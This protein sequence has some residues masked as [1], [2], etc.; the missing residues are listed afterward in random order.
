MAESDSEMEPSTYDRQKHAPLPDWYLFPP[1]QTSGTTFRLGQIVLLRSSDHWYKP[2]HIIRVD[3]KC[4]EVCLSETSHKTRL[5]R[6]DQRRLL[7]PY[8]G[9]ST[10]GIIVVTSETT[11]YRHL[12][13]Y[14]ESSDRVLEIGC[15]SG[16]TSKLILRHCQSW[17]GL[18][19]SLEMLNVCQETL[20]SM[21]QSTPHHSVVV[22]ALIDPQR[23]RKEATK[24]GEPNVV[25]LDIGGNR[26]G[27]NVL[28]MIAWIL[29]EFQLRLLVMK[30][31]ELVR[32]I[33]ASDCAINEVTGL[34]DK[35]Q[36]WY[37]R[38]QHQRA[39]PKHPKKA[40]LVMSPRDPTMAI[41][42]YHNYHKNGCKKND[43]DFDHEYCH[44]CLC[45]GH[46]AMECPTL[47]GINDSKELKGIDDKRD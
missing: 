18:D 10:A 17:V 34:I 8:H 43:C 3:S 27:I 31:R 6:K 4:V 47:L 30:S 35:G 21:Q 20:S 1:N 19:T 5:N 40:A 26:E 9:P 42:R 33:L 29:E 46:V 12:V 32:S 2:G 36:D 39:I 41:C 15:S 25:F 23:A 22:N 37:Q 44:A 7:L 11:H 16:E 45:K 14:I 24:F 28:R 13:G 38:Q